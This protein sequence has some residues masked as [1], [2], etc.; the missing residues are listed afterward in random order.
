MTI[1]M[2][3]NNSRFSSIKCDVSL[4]VA[5]AGKQ[6]VVAEANLKR[7]SCVLCIGLRVHCLTGFLAPSRGRIAYPAR[8][9]VLRA[10]NS[11]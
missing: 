1:K 2:L 4:N 9:R 7:L 10:Y 5:S 6:L 3:T 8:V 11:K